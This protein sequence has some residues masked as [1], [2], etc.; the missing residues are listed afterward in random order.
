MYKYIVNRIRL[1]DGGF[2][3][4]RANSLNKWN[5]KNWVYFPLKGKLVELVESE[6][7]CDFSSEGD[8]SLKGKANSKYV[9]SH[10]KSK[11]KSI[12]V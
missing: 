12:H 4:Y 1:V 2:D 7:L 5:L 3:T 10:S 8:S 11:E 9:L 6:E